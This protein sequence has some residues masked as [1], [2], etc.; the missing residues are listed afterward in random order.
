M[1]RKAARSK[2]ITRRDISPSDVLAPAT[3]DSL[4]GMGIARNAFAVLP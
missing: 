2:N 4:R 1:T 3:N